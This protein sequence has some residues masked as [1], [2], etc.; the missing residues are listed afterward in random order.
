MARKPIPYMDLDRGLRLP[1]DRI[2]IICYLEPLA[3]SPA[4]EIRHG[5]K[6]LSR[7]QSMFRAL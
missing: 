7:R 4:R 1:D 3:V 5:N 6:W 2:L